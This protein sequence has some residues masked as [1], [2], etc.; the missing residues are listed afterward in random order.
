MGC[1][2]FIPSDPCGCDSEPLL[3]GCISSAASARICTYLYLLEDEAYVCMH[4]R[5]ATQQSPADGEI[6]V[7]HVEVSISLTSKAFENGSELRHGDI[8]GIVA[9]R[10]GGNREGKVYLAEAVAAI[11]HAIM[12][13]VCLNCTTPSTTKIFIS[14]RHYKESCRFAQVPWEIWLSSRPFLH[15]IIVHSMYKMT[16]SLSLSYTHHPEVS[17]RYN[18]VSTVPPSGEMI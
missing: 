16:R 7:E 14:A 18:D 1:I 5:L 13:Q 9:G 12:E 2:L 10:Y 17:E 15:H 11:I 6:N 3:V 8:S 4:S